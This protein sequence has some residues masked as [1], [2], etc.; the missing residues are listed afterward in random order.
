MNRFMLSHAAKEAMLAKLIAASSEFDPATIKLYLYSTA[1]IDTK[2]EALVTYTQPGNGL[3][4]VKTVSAW[5]A[6][7]RSPEGF[8]FVTSPLITWTPTA[9]P[10][11]ESVVGVG[12]ASATGIGNVF[13][14]GTFD[15]PEAVQFANQPVTVVI[16]LGFDGPNFYVAAR[17][18]PV[19]A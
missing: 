13:A 12:I 14:I 18:I 6:V 7:S 5:S 8:A 2:D 4:A 15:G 9:D 17:R 3:N 11:D 16:E 1:N 10:V 19:G